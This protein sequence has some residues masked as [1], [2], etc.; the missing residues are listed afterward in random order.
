MLYKNNEFILWLINLFQIN[1]KVATNVFIAFSIIISFWSTE[2]RNSSTPRKC[3]ILSIVIKLYEFR[4]QLI[5]NLVLFPNRV[6]RKQE[7]A[8]EMLTFLLEQLDS[9]TNLISGEKY[10]SETRKSP[11]KI[12]FGGTLQNHCQFLN[13]ILI[14][15]N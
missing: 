5:S 3:T 7:D 12:L 11:I 4:L 14:K 13:P 8:H 10:G 2:R 15:N 6:P 1:A 9:P